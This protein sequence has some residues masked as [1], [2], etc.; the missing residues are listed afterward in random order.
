VPEASL[1]DD[2]ALS[3]AYLGRDLHVVTVEGELDVAT[4][5]A[6]R[7]ELRRIADD[8]ATQ[9]VVD[10]LRVSLL[11]SVTLGI[12]VDGSKRLSSRD[13]TFRIV[14]D[15]RRVARIIEITGLNRILRLHATLRDA[16]EAPVEGSLARAL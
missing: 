1:P 7:D 5:P 14:C 6:L 12:L 8:G 4:A 13:G 15:D 2:F 10:L 3:S 16:L 9:V 11:D